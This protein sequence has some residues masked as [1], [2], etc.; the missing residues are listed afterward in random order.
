MKK[1]VVLTTGGTIASKWSKESG[2]YTS[3][4]MTGEELIDTNKF[5]LD[6]HIETETVFQIPSNTMDFTRLMA[7]RERIIEHM[8]DPGVQGIVITH[9]TDTL[10]ESAYFLDLT[11]NEKRPIVMTGSQRTPVEEGTDAYTNIRDAIVAAS[12]PDCE[13]LGVLVVFNEGLYLAKYVKKMH[14]GN[15]HAFTSFGYGMVGFVDKGTAVVIQKP[16]QREYYPVQN[17]QFPCVEIIK[18]YLGGDGKFIEYAISTGVEGL[19]LEG[20]GRG[21][22][23]P[24][25]SQAVARASEA[26]IYIVLTSTC[27]H[28]RVYPV[29]DFTGSVKD[30]LNQGVI[31]GHDYDSRKARIKLLVLLAAGITEK[32][33][34]QAAF[35]H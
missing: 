2:L 14:A 3:G 25:C 12:S 21:H 13:D 33:R 27:E 10:E 9:G 16:N 15:P 28:G 17:K 35:H 26:G 6:V 19:I 4:A 34:L 32:R 31:T 23:H 29:Y 7:L 5:G 1:V 24:A 8:K 22:L 18:G 11:L 20:L 30:F